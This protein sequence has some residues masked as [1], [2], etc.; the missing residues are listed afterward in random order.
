MTYATDIAKTRHRVGYYV[1]F[2]GIPTRLATHDFSQAPWSLSGTFLRCIKEGSVTGGPQ[3]LDRARGLVLPDGFAF[4]AI[5]TTSVHQLLRRRGGTEYTLSEAIDA[6]DDD[7]TLSDETLDEGAVLYLDQE[8]ITLGAFNAVLGFYESCT[9]GAHGSVA[10]SH[11][12]GAVVSTVPRYWRGRRAQLFAVNLATGTAQAIRT[13]ILS[14]SPRFRD[15]VYE[16]EFTDL[17]RELARPLNSGWLPEKVLSRTVQDGDVVCDV[18]DA[19][20]FVDDTV[21]GHNYVKASFGEDFE[22]YQLTAGSVSTANDTVTLSALNL[23]YSTHGGPLQA[24]EAEDVELQQVL[25]II[26]DPAI[27]ALMLMLSRDGDLTNH[28]TYDLLAGRPAQATTGLAPRRQGA[29]LPASWVDVD[30]WEEAIG[31]PAITLY[32]D[33]PEVLLDVLVEE[34]LWH[35][36]GKLYI[37]GSG[38]LS[39]RRNLPAIP[40]S[41]IEVLDGNDRLVSEVTAV[42]DESEILALASIECNWDPKYREF[43]RKVNVSFADTTPIYGESLASVE[44]RSRTTWV[45]P[46]NPSPLVSAPFDNETALTVAFDRY[47]ARTRNGLRRTSLTLPWS[48][49]LDAIPGWAFKLTHTTLPDGEGGTGVT[50]RQYEVVSSSPD[51]QAGTVRIEA[52]E[53]PEGWLVAPSGIIDDPGSGTSPE[54]TLVG[55]TDLYDSNP[56]RDFMADATVRIYDASASPPFS[57]SDTAAIAAVSDAFIQL[58]DVSSMSFTPASGDLVVL[59]NSA[60]TGN[61]NAGDADVQ[62]HLYMTDDDGVID[63]GGATERDGTKWS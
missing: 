33:E 17:Q 29:G 2:D 37:N 49:H 18:R 20:A 47:A 24:G 59:E 16:L 9:R 36:G 12:Q 6:D 34:L 45:G 42:D 50:E 8:T 51:Y 52:E 3:T 5:A 48:R 1:V 46:A 41:S 15:G 38:Q 23:V 22:V 53:M 44:F 63:S 62:D 31:G 27:I 28:G 61:T 54:V 7:I 4:Q 40:Q 10:V 25:Y 56:G 39:F 35:L 30:S 11:A 58:D 43:L 19:A 21:A 32:S 14:S 26:G 13:G 55:D 57:S 60:N